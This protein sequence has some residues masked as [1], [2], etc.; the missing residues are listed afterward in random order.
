MSNYRTRKPFSNSKRAADEFKNGSLLIAKDCRYSLDDYS[1]RLNNNVL[2]VGG[3]GTG[4]TRTIVTPNIHEAVGSYII[5]D[6]KGNLHKKYANY[7]R[8]KGYKIQVVDFVHPE[9]SAH[10]NPMFHLK[11]SQDVLR[12]ATLIVDKENSAGSYDPFW[13]E[14]TTIFLCALIGY[15]LET[16]YKPFT[17]RSILSLMA[18]GARE[19]CADDDDDERTSMLSRRFDALR[20]RDP[21]S[22]ACTQFDSANAAPYKTY[23]TSRVTLAAKF[24]NFDTREIRQMMNGNDFDFSALGREKTALFVIVSDTD[25]SMDALVNMFFSQAMQELCRFADDKCR[26]SRLPVPVRFI[27][28]DFATNCRIADFPRV[29]STIRS[30]GISTMLMIQSEAQLVKGYGSD[31]LTIISNCDTYVYLGGNDISTARSVSER[32]D[33]S[34]RQILNMPIGSCWVF[35]RGSEPI[36]TKTLTAERYVKEMLKVEETA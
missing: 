36:Y 15:M 27:L 22:W 30:R 4:K 25:R 11:N 17:F 9:K 13:D 2:V 7:L 29:I 3:S 21:D 28:D 5:S 20:G 19:T 24:A 35:R 33:K 8:E 26:D 16:E 18:E 6:P 12:L 23:D 34:L 1:T 10:Y 31:A 32:S 14:I